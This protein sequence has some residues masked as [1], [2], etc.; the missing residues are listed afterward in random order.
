MSN[1]LNRLQWNPEPVIGPAQIQVA[2]LVSEL[3][4]GTD[5]A[6]LLRSH[7]L[8]PADLVAALAVTALG[9]EQSLGLPLIQGR[10][11]R[12]NIEPALQAVARLWKTVTPTAS[13]VVAAGLL[14]IF[15]FWD[16]SHTAAQEADDRGDT[17]KLGS[18]WHAIAH[19]RE[20]DPGNS[21]YW[22]RRVGRDPA[23]IYSALVQPATAVIEKTGHWTLT[24]QLIQNGRWDPLAL[25][26]ICTR[27]RPGTAEEGLARKLQRLEML[28]CLEASL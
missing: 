26:E 2:A 24:V 21:A 20:P 11:S 15:E 1:L 25:I 28:A 3:E 27:V 10:A 22:Y 5:P 4:S 19:R 8:V 7:S 9:G 18:L 14:Q 6:H 23:G 13:L 12:P 17:T 16:A